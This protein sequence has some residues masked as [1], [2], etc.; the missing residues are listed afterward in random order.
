[1]AVNVDV[2]KVVVGFNGDH[3]GFTTLSKAIAFIEEQFADQDYS[4]VYAEIET[5]IGASVNDSVD[6]NIMDIDTF[7]D[8]FVS[9]EDED[10]E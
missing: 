1:M 8:Y 5:A 7:V 2:H 9:D 10:D 6:V 3:F 4:K